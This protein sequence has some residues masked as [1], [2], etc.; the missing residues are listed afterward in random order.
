MAGVWSTV[1]RGVVGLFI[2]EVDP[3]GLM[4][5]LDEVLVERMAGVLWYLAYWRLDPVRVRSGRRSLDEQRRLY[6]R[7]RTRQE[8][9]RA[10]VPEEYSVRAA[11]RVTFQWP[12]LSKHLS[13]HAVDVTFAGLTKG[14][15]DCVS[16]L[17]E[18]LGVKWGGDWSKKDYGHFEV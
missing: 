5:D 4:L 6:G 18:M 17:C 14:Q 1:R 7:G 16:R 3:M 11:Q 12:E 10:R 8:C 9:K 15:A 13:G 2:Q